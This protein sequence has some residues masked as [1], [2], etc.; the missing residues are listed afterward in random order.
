M[1][2]YHS[3]T[4]IALSARQQLL[5]MA[6]THG[7]SGRPQPVLVKLSLH[8]WGAARHVQL[9]SACTGIAV[10]DASMASG[11][12]LVAAACGR[13]TLVLDSSDDTV[14]TRIHGT[15]SGS[16]HAVAWHSHHKL[17]TNDLGILQLWDL[18]H[19]AKPL[20]QEH[21]DVTGVHTLLSAGS[22][23]IAGT[24]RGSYGVKLL[25]H[26]SICGL[27]HNGRPGENAHVC[28]SVATAPS[29][30]DIDVVTSFKQGHAQAAAGA[31]PAHHTLGVLKADPSTGLYAWHKATQMRGHSCRDTATKS[32]TMTL[33]Q[34]SVLC[35]GDEQSGALQLWAWD[36]PTQQ[37][38]V[39]PQLVGQLAPHA[40]DV[41]FKHVRQIAAGQCGQG[42]WLLAALRT[43]AQSTAR[44]SLTLHAVPVC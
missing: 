30:A 37:H 10:Q 32:A 31:A 43:Q 18:R 14:V 21:T 1:Q 8:S 40:R 35:S 7:N 24:L 6:A 41:G 16:C 42:K 28:V 12:G 36:R 29:G 9:H 22:G 20:Q 3:A 23:A 19:T 17:W 38:A 44:P 15:G 34:R 5:Y 33:A 26:L 27:T 39:Q 13:C 2:E 25:P 4:A 11:Q